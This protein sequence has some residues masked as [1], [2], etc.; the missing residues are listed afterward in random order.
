MPAEVR[1]WEKRS[2]SPAM[3]AHALTDGRG[4]QGN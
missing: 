2:G 3:G 1:S 4:D